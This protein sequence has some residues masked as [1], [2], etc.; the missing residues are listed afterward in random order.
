MYRLTKLT[1]LLLCLS[2]SAQ[3]QQVCTTDSLGNREL[4]GISGSSDSNV[5][6]VG[7]KGEIYQY[8]GTSWNPMTNSSDEDLN[9]VEVVG[10][11]AFAVGK[12]GETLQLSGSTWISHTGFTDEDLLGVWA[13]SGSEA[14]VVG[15]EGTVYTYNGSAWTDSSGAAGTGNEDLTDVW[16]DANGVYII[17][18]KGDLYR[19]DRTLGTWLPKDSSC[20]F[21]NNF[22]D[23]WGDGNGNIYLVAK[24]DVYLYDGAS[25]AVVATAS[26]DLF[27]ISGSSQAG[28]VVAVGKKGTVFEFDGSSWSES[29]VGDEDLRDDWVSAA[30]N[31]YYAGKK[32]ELTTCRL[33]QVI[34]DW[35]LDECT[36]GIA[37]SSVTDSGPNGL[38]GTAVG[39][40]AA[41]NEGQLCAAAAFDGSS[42]YVEVP[43]SPEIDITDGIGMAVWVRHNATPLTDWEAILAKGDSAYR[44]HLNGGCSIADSLPGNTRRGFTFGLNGGCGGADLN[45]NVVP[46][47]GVWY[48]I[49]ATY[50]GAQMRLYID[51]SLVTSASYSEPINTNNFDLFIGENSQRRGRYWDGDIDELTL[52]DGAITAAD[53]ADHMNRTRPCTNCS[54]VE[55]RINHD[56][57]GIHCLDETVQVNI[58]DSLTGSPRTD[59]NDQVTLDTMTG[60]GTWTLISG[61]GTFVD[62]VSDDGVATYTWP[63]G[64]S[65]AVFALS[66][67]QGPPT[68][69][70]DVYQS[71]DPLI[72]DDDSEGDIVFSASGFT[73]TAAP[74]SNPPPVVIVPFDATQ[75]AGTDF[76]IYLAAYGQ[77]AN[78]PA[79]GI[80]ESY[81]GPQNLKFW[82]D[83]ADPAG[84]AVA[85]SVDGNPIGTN[86]A[87]AVDQGVNF[88]NGQAAVTAKYK[89]VGLV[90]VLVKDDSLS[91]PDLPA[92]IRGAT[93]NF[94]VKPAYFGLSNINDSA[95]NPNPAAADASGNV[96]VAAGDPFS[97]TVTA[98]DAEGDV[99]PNF[100]QESTPET[101]RLS[102]SLVAPASGNDPGISPALGFGAF[103]AGSAIGTTFAWPEVG[104]I[105]LQPSIGDGDY[106]GGGDVVGAASG[107]VGRFVPDHFTADLNVPLLATQCGS[108]GFSYIGQAF[109]YT[110][111]PVITVTARA[112]GG[113]T[114]QNYT[115]TFFKI[116]NLS[117]LNRAYAAATGTLDPSGLP[118]TGVDPQ[119]ADAGAGVGSLLFSAGSGLSFLRSSAEAAFDADISLSIDVLDTD[120]VTTLSS[121]VE[122]STIG[123]DN[124]ASM[125]YGRVRLLNALGSELVNLAVPMRTEYFVDAATGFVTHTADSC[126]DGLALSLGNFSANLTAGETCVV[127]A[128][129][130]GDSGA[131]CAAAGPAGQ[132]YRTPS[133]GGNFNLFL[134]APGAGNDGSV[135]VSVDVPAWL[136][137]DWDAAAA[138]DEDPHATATFG[139]YDGD[140]RRIYTRDL[141]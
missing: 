110:I 84:G 29:K 13:A 132:R 63:L 79:C 39:G 8:N 46:S 81:S 134:Q 52:W 94:V 99:T 111:N 70:I 4:R 139:I 126:T 87:A 78:D 71:N 3:A 135:D 88:V 27:G 109:D 17:S 31:A 21:G 91:H 116:T 42:S 75:F 54:N 24:K 49:A 89:D 2:V 125:R 83:R 113:T 127:D 23:L 10:S 47:P 33:P 7:K 93:A 76:G 36:L 98:F 16:G 26:R 104:I 66:Y 97:V 51:G 92:G 44:L 64:E 65:N 56:N 114:T 15:K 107:N 103:S 90:Q 58:V 35:H 37:G 138:G 48:H 38:T 18:K 59:Y 130:P 108:G 11:T 34:A 9:D 61:S 95:G 28:N 102:S 72:R 74:L 141:Y 57:N 67:T 53:V 106:L 73:L 117:L 120:G 55:I 121:P 6:A 131:G 140:A 124:G 136:E 77:T 82:F 119:I 118:G 22:E 96:F 43:D 115:S 14:Y 45:S 32:G 69:D 62:A 80:I 100:G 128:G 40:L 30:G 133:L 86:E 20:S 137:Y 129:S 50:D 122:F 68:F 12:D 85:V 60:V 1:L 112:A 123:F 105:T 19:Y 25:C 5:I 101:V 41:E